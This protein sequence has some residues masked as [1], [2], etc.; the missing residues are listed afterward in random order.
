MDTLLPSADWAKAV[1]TAVV[2]V[3]MISACSLMCLAFYN[4]LAAMVTRLRVFQRECLE[5]QEALHAEGGSSSNPVATKRKQAVIGMLQQQTGGVLRRARLLRATLTFLLSAIVLL[6]LSSLSLGWSA[7]APALLI[8]A[9]LLFFVGCLSVLTAVGF[10]I[11]E[12]RA[13][14]DPIELES[15]FVQDLMQDSPR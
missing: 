13:S 9:A 14:L 2:P 3:V 5:N 4:R 10:A 12:V 11:A 8:P 15:R 7:F 1:T 6:I